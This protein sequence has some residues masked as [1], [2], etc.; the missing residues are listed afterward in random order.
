MDNKAYVDFCGCSKLKHNLR[1]KS[2]NNNL[3][4]PNTV[5]AYPN[6][7]PV[8][9]YWQE[10]EYTDNEFLNSI[11]W[12]T[13]WTNLPC[14]KLTYTINLGGAR[15]SVDF[16]GLDIPDIGVIGFA[17][18]SQ[19]VI[20]S[21]N[22]MMNDLATFINLQVENVGANV[23]DAILSINFLDVDNYFFPYNGIGFPPANLNEPDYV[24]LS[25]YRNL[26]DSYNVSGNMYTSYQASLEE[27][28]AKGGE[29]YLVMLHELGHALG[30]AHPQD[31]GGNS[32]IMAGIT[33][34]VGLYGSLGTYNANLHPITCMSYNFKNTPFLEQTMN[35]NISGFMGTFGPLD[36]MA[37]QYM[38]GVNS[39]YNSG[40]TTYTFPNNTTNKFWSCIYDTGGIDTIDA[41]QSNSNTTI[42]IRNSTLQ[43]QTD[44]A[45]VKFSYNSFGGITIAKSSGTI[46][47]VI[48]SA[49]NDN[50]IG[51]NC[52]NEFDLS[53]GGNDN[54]D[55]KDGFDTAF[56]NNISYSNVTFNVNSTTG[57]ITI[58]NVSNGDVIHLVNVEK[59]VFSDKVILIT[60]NIINQPI[61]TENGITYKIYKDYASVINTNVLMSAITIPKTIQYYYYNYPVTIIEEYAFANKD[62][63]NQY[64]DTLTTVN[65][66]N[67]IIRIDK[68][69]FKDCRTLITINL[70]E[71]LA[72]IDEFLFLGCSAL[73]EITIP[74][75]VT[76]IMFQAFY[77]CSSLITINWG[78]SLTTIN[79]EVFRGC[80]SLSNIILSPN[81][82]YI[83]E[84]AFYDCYNSQT[85]ILPSKLTFIGD[86]AFFNCSNAQPITLSSKLTFM[87]GFAFGSCTKVTNVDLPMITNIGNGVFNNCTN[88]STVKF[89]SNKISLNYTVYDG[90]KDI[91]EGCSKLKHIYIN[92]ECIDSLMPYLFGSSYSP[93]LEAHISVFSR[94]SIYKYS[95]TYPSIVNYE[96]FN[97]NNFL[98]GT[99]DSQFYTP[100]DNVSVNGYIIS[101]KQI[102]YIPN[103]CTVYD[104]TYKIDKIL[105]NVFTNI[106]I[107]IF[108]KTEM[109]IVE[110]AFNG[111]ID[112]VFTGAIPKVEM[113]STM[114]HKP[115]LNAYILPIYNTP[116]NIQYLKQYFTNIYTSYV[117]GCNVRTHITCS[118]NNMD[119]NIHI[120][121]LEPGMIIKTFNGYNTI[122]NITKTR[123]R[124]NSQNQKMYKM[125]DLIVSSKVGIIINNFVPNGVYY[126]M[127]NDKYI[128][129]AESHPEFSMLD[130]HRSYCL[131]TIVIDTI[132]E[133]PSFYA[134][135]IP[136]VIKLT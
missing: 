5:Y 87:G 10:I 7:R 131:Y 42:D 108:P 81:V 3:N 91:F 38:Y 35:G 56:F 127:I 66:P 109:T 74:N 20:D 25:N 71:R 95:N 130:N 44:Y 83:G 27:S 126:G 84:N 32:T 94:E 117:I 59:V 99:Y 96:F 52:N 45:G 135:N 90:I 128:I 106:K 101:E 47:N 40:N 22:T 23:A 13:K 115:F 43:N 12:G 31:D 6:G 8:K 133:F 80:N 51:N 114:Q 65:L 30:L 118:I 76:S 116:C 92:N 18:V 78:S 63:L 89:T 79:N 125:N 70:P 29:R 73:S 86:R 15:T 1:T 37:L 112:F 93:Q 55:G 16:S 69:C 67:T 107:A 21:V 64:N 136:V 53:A 120:E 61:I 54:I 26:T 49:Y 134:N 88:L 60:N 62:I 36:I 72:R 75:S 17:N 24:D 48:G 111:T 57:V 39:N 68:G 77:N 2:I 9:T 28:F 132:E 11:L 105:T 19:F 46:E 34:Q 113:S 102:I 41:S 129:T 33:N 58:T 122:L 4:T 124:N 123:I 121:S 110:G 50:I 97:L 85:I 104:K 98:I 103:E 100:P 14:N 82:E 119:R